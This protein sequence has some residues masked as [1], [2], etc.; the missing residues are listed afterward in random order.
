MD[1]LSLYFPWLLQ[2]L[3]WE[4]ISARFISTP[5]SRTCVLK[6]SANRKRCNTFGIS[7]I[8]RARS[9]TPFLLKSCPSVKLF[10]EMGIVYSPWFE[11][12]FQYVFN[13]YLFWIALFF[14]WS[15]WRNI[16]I[17][18]WF[19]IGLPVLGCQSGRSSGINHLPCFSSYEIKS[20]WVTWQGLWPRIF[21]YVVSEVCGNVF[22]LSR[23]PFSQLSMSLLHPS[24][25]LSVAWTEDFCWLSSQECK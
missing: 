20:R 4:S 21:F 14:L 13:S 6:M 5:F 17:K 3:L 9:Q 11:E 15:S 7:C 22:P 8:R 16:Y 10:S 1:V 12:W 23:V 2:Y 24:W 25:V 18:Q 19:A